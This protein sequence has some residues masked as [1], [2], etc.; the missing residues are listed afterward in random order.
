VSCLGEWFARETRGITRSSDDWNPHRYLV[1]LV[2]TP[3]TESLA[4]S[5]VSVDREIQ[6]VRILID[7]ANETTGVPIWARLGALVGTGRTL[8]GSLH[9]PRARFRGAVCRLAARVDFADGSTELPHKQRAR[10]ISLP[11]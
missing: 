10:T 6:K 5:A 9:L 7:E 2:Y 4:V 11:G 1:T 3:E 8:A